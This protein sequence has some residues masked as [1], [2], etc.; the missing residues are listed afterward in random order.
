M[1]QWSRLGIVFGVVLA[2]LLAAPAA[3]AAC[4]GISIVTTS[5]E[6]GRSGIWTEG[7][8]APSYYPGYL[9]YGNSPPV[10]SSLE[11]V[12]WALGRGDPDGVGIDN[13]THDSDSWFSHRYAYGYHYAGEIFTSWNAAG[14]DGCI[15]GAG[16]TSGLDGTE[17]TAVL[18][19]DQ[20]QG[21][22]YFALLSARIS[23]EGHSEL[24]QPGDAP[25]I[26]RPAP[27]SFVVG[28][29]RIDGET[30]L[31]TLSSPDVPTDALY[32]DPDCDG[33][34][35]IGYKIYAQ[36]LPRNAPPPADRTRDDGDPQTGWE[37][38]EGGEGPAGEPIPLG[39]PASV[40]IQDCACGSPPIRTY[41][42][43]SL[44]F[45]SDFELPFLSASPATLECGIFNFDEDN[46]CY[47]F[48]HPD[49]APG[50]DC[51]DNDIT[52]Y[53]GA[54]QLCDGVNNDCDDPL[55]P[56][57]PSD[58]VDAD[59]DGHRGCS[60]D[61]DDTDPSV[62]PEAIEICDGID[63][64]CDGLVDESGSSEDFDGDGL[65]DLCDNCILVR[66]PSQSDTDDDAEGDS[67]D[68]DDGVIFIHFEQAGQV[69][70]QEEIGFDD[71]NLYRGDLAVL[72]ATGAYTQAVGSNALADRRCDLDGPSLADE[73]DLLPGQVA[74][75]LVS[76]NAGGSEG[77]LGT[78][79]DGFP[80]P[81]QS[82]CH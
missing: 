20:S 77:D 78:D 41:L 35:V 49:G 40:P 9:P 19:G 3:S 29:T 25:I 32:L 1:D 24:N 33:N 79:G 38:A 50:P 46:D 37:V 26:L 62:N 22:G 42:A 67:C 60:G 71:W 55:W 73:S 48:M 27:P 17:C 2:W 6:Q 34:A 80:R 36:V 57:P 82:P 63:N 74:F 47:P 56:N 21:Q 44:V 10:T 69:R 81:N 28:S 11:G 18:L 31:L 23:P 65:G 72:R 30:F 51:D 52:V 43:A 15:F 45:D 58:E 68:L 5:S 16:P 64:D 7:V 53:P 13:G 61:C 75:F 66:N 70:W 14:V 8:F 59:G 12:F 39:S 76:G 4:A 54:P